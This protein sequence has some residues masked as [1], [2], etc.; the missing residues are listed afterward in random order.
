MSTFITSDCHFFHKNIIKFS[1][2]P[3]IDIDHMNESLIK[4]HNRVVKPGDI[5]YN[6]GDF[7][8]DSP[9][10]AVSIIKRLNG[11]HRFIRGNHDAWLFNKS[12]NNFD[13][14]S[15]IHNELIRQGS[16]TEKVEW[17]EDY[18][19]FRENKVL[20]CLMHFPLFTWHHSYKGSINLYGH[21]HANIEDQITGRQMD[22][23]VDNAFRL[24][25]EYRPFS[26][27]EVTKM[28]LAR[29]VVCP[30]MKKIA[31]DPWQKD[32]ENIED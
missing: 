17:I 8:F 9:E 19:E 30:E 14:K 3:F 22:V 21:C 24:T 29:N 26:L 11:K 20:Y 10:K 23:G 31:Q 13:A 27:E 1:N 16:K 2:R 18:F 6:L 5:V 7:T 15:V 28:L 12:E 4:E 25:G 32:N